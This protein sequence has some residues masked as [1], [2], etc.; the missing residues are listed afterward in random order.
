M[1]SVL[2]AEHWQ[3]FWRLAAALVAGSLIGLERTRRGRHAG[4]REHALV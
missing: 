2:S 1:N 4:L 3:I